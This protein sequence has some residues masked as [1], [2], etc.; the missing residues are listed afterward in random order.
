MI[1]QFYFK[2]LICYMG[3]C[4]G[5][6]MVYYWYLMIFWKVLLERFVGK[7]CGG[8]CGSFGENDNKVTKRHQCDEK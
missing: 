1:K 3:E 2:Y 6:L 4:A 7:L 8:C 5:L